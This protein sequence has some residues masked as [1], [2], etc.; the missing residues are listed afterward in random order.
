[1]TDATSRKLR[2]LAGF[3][4]YIGALWLLWDTVLVYPLKIFVVLLHEVSHAAAALATGGAVDRITLDPNQGGA[5]YTMGGSRFVTL[6][7][8]YLGSLAWGALMVLAARARRVRPNVAIGLIG[9]LVVALTAVYVRNLF[10]IGFGVLF[11]AALVLVSGKLS[12]AA[13]RSLL[14]TLGMTSSLYAILD[15]KSDV[16]D[17]PHL[18]SDAHM[19]AELTGIPTLVWGL[20]WIGLALWVTFLLLRW[21]WKEA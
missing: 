4:V 9:G 8:G 18:P 13:N 10:G 12:L 17:R 11:G 2:F 3:A 7:A 20:L 1:M 21:A 5:T 6:S 14:L 15:I 19:L 16:L